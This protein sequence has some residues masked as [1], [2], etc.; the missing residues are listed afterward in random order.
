MSEGERVLTFRFSLCFQYHDILYPLL[1]VELVFWRTFEYVELQCVYVSR[2]KLFKQEEK[3]RNKGLKWNERRN[4]ENTQT[5]YNNHHHNNNNNSITVGVRFFSVFFHSFHFSTFFFLFFFLHF[6]FFVHRR[7][8]GITIAIPYMCVL[9]LLLQFQHNW[10][11][12]SHFL[13]AYIFCTT[14]ATTTTTNVSLQPRDFF[15]Y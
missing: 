12:R 9:L 8:D 11:C 13:Y 6:W 2:R 1:F 7:L 4:A 3:G 15:L 14:E 5:K 10:R